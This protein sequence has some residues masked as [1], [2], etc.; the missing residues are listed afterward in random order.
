MYI[1]LSSD[2]E[3]FHPFE[4]WRAALVDPLEP[5]VLR[6]REGVP[7]DLLEHQVLVWRCRL[8]YSSARFVAS[9]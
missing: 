4:P 1:S 2:E 9:E 6:V 8:T 5:P 7:I 3:P